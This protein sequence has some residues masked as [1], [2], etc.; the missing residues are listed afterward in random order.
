MPILLDL[1][2]VMVSNL[3]ASLGNHKNAEVDESM[4]R[5]MC[6]NSLRA[7]RKKFFNDYGEIVICADSSNYWRKGIFP[8]YKASRKASR[9]KSELDWNAIFIALNN[10]RED[11]VNFMPYKV[12]RVDRAE[13][14]DI[15]ASIGMTYGT[16]LAAGERFLILSSD[17]DMSQLQKFANIDQYDP[18]RKRWIN[19]STPERTLFEHI[20]RGD[21]G[22]GVPN[23]LSADDTFVTAARQKPIRSTQIDAWFAGAE[24]NEEVKRNFKRNQMLID[25]EMIPD[26]IKSQVIDQYETPKGF[27]REKM[28]NFFIEKRLKNLMDSINDF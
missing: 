16:P 28:F 7:N 1:S 25:F 17:K 2:N 26:H 4:L 18:V 20:V 6:L 13:A 5:H 27:G 14:D 12:L 11:L 9:E 21:V 22:D 24:M 23:I 15:I 8:Y 3:M 10:I 19:N